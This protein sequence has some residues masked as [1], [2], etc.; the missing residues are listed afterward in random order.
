MRKWPEGSITLLIEKG[1]RSSKLKA[2]DE[3]VTLSLIFLNTA[4]IFF[5]LI[6]YP[7]SAPI[8]LRR[9]IKKLGFYGEILLNKML[10]NWQ[11]LLNKVLAW[12]FNQEWPLIC[13]DTVFYY[14]VHSIIITLYTV[15]A[16][17]RDHSWLNHHSS[18]LFSKICQLLNI[19]FSNISP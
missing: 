10:S 2:K 1:F 17:I 18:T 12:R 13:A 4:Y 8:D 3:L 6:P 7:L 5:L 15:S 16:H 19:L 14:F 9:S 11:I